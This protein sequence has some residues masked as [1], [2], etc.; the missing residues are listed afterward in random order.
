MTVRLHRLHWPD[1]LD[2]G[3][4]PCL[5]PTA[6][7]CRRDPVGPP[8]ALQAERGKNRREERAGRQRMAFPRTS[9]KRHKAASLGSLAPFPRHWLE[10]SPCSINIP[11][12]MLIG[13]FRCS[14]RT[15][16]RRTGL[17]PCNPNGREKYF[18][19]LL[20]DEL[21]V[22]LRGGFVSVVA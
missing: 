8:C 19:V 3:A 7:T 13:A 18:G 10:L 15:W 1:R 2:R 20:R 6:A 16:P 4:Q 17:N 21:F 9:K 5:L 14:R 11:P 12:T 22:S